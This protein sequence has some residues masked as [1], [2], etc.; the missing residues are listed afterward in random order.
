MKHKSLKELRNNQAM[1]YFIGDDTG[2]VPFL[3]K[4]YYED[5]EIIGENAHTGEMTSPAC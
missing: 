5:D 2:K 3:A 1:V 4:R